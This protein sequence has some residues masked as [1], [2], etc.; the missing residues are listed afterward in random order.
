MYV[1]LEELKDFSHKFTD[2][3]DA[4]PALCLAAAIDAV[5]KYL[6]YNVEEYAAAKSKDGDIA[7]IPP[8]IKMTTLQIASLMLESTQGN[9]ATASTTFADIGSRVFNDFNLDRLLKQ[10]EPYRLYQGDNW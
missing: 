1:T 10:I 9:I 8:L 6:H 2:S 4:T 7:D 5:Q 3:T